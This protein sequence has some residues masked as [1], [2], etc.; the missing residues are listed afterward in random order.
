MY[1]HEKI[2]RNLPEG[3]SMLKTSPIGKVKVPGLTSGRYLLLDVDPK[4]R[5]V[6]PAD[7]HRL[8]LLPHV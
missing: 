5:Q 2:E 4:D 6:D 3:R 7:C 1:L 8:P